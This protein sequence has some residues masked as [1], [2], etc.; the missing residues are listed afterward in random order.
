[1]KIKPRFEPSPK[2]YLHVGGAR[3]D[4]SYWLFASNIGGEFVLLIEDS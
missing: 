1:M 3:T 4:L 2:G